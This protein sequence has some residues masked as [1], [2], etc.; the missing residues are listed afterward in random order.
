MLGVVTVLIAIEASSQIVSFVESPAEKS[1]TSSTS[2][3]GEQPPVFQFSGVAGLNVFTESSLKNATGAIQGEFNI[4][5]HVRTLDS[6]K[7]KLGG[8]IKIMTAYNFNA[9]V[10]KTD[11]DS[12]ILSDVLFAERSKNAFEIMFRSDLMRWFGRNTFL[13]RPHPTFAS[14]EA[15]SYHSLIPT[16]SFGY[17]RWNFSEDIIG[18][19]SLGQKPLLYADRLHATSWE[20]GLEA[21]HSIKQKNNHVG[22]MLSGHFGGRHISQ[23]SLPVFNELF[24][25]AVMEERAL[26]DVFNYWGATVAIQ[27]NKTRLSFTYQDLWNDDGI[28]DLRASGGIFLMKITT[29]ADFVKL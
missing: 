1:A 26:R 10:G 2:E 5:D 21:W 8:M 14:D 12:I 4:V 19:D 29:V 7:Y 28:V 6:Q 9:E 23:G 13:D 3:K 18:E 20:F 17:A 25:N 15:I 24:K 27:V 22:V 11:R 16:F